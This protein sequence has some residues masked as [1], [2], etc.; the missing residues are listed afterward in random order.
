MTV[1]SPNKFT[2]MLIQSGEEVSESEVLVRTV[3]RV[4]S[5]NITSV[6]Q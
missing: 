4:L 6:A 2:F 1:N 5:E 3:V